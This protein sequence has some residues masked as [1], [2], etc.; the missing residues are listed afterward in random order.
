MDRN[1]TFSLNLWRIFLWECIPATIKSKFFSAI[2][3]KQ[4]LGK[5]AA[6]E[7]GGERKTAENIEIKGNYSCRFV[8]NSDD[9][10]L[11]TAC[12]YRAM[13]ERNCALC[14]AGLCASND[15]YLFE[16]RRQWQWQWRQRKKLCQNHWSEEIFSSFVLFGHISFVL[17]KHSTTEPLR[18]C[19]HCAYLRPPSWCCCVFRFANDISF[20]FNTCLSLFSLF[21]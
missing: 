18:P 6:D 14:Y 17:L 1:N 13:V 12:K 3:S 8:W 16:N 19:M 7:R 21:F 10:M 15:V 2:Y 20:I 9:L 5:A 11:P 4:R